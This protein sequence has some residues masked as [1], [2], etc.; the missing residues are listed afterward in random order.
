MQRRKRKKNRQID[1]ED[2]QLR[3]APRNKENLPL[4]VAAWDGGGGD[5][6]GDRDGEETGRDLIDGFTFWPARF[7]HVVL[8]T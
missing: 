4:R 5:A 6:D 7:K 1:K 8:L 3:F 2:L